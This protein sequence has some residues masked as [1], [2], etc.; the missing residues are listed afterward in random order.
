MIDFIQGPLVWISFIIFGGGLVVQTF[1]L[2]KLTRIKETRRVVP[3]KGFI[4]QIDL[5]IK[6]R[7]FRYLVFQRVSPLAN[8]ICLVLASFIFH[9]CLIVTPIFVLGHNIMLDTAFGISFIS[10]PEQVTDIMTKFVLAGALMFLMR[11]LLLRR[12]RIISTVNDYLLLLI[13]VAPFVTGFMVY[14]HILNYNT[15]ILLH[16]LFGEL[17]LIMI[18]FSKF[19]HMVFFFISRF[20][21]VS[22]HSL[23]NS[24][25]SWHF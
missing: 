11:R 2:L 20:M 4:P 24:K 16:I 10:F 6:E 8:N 25:R 9:V 5:S 19:F 17:M 13:A 22:E 18:P 14:H 3:D 15:I 12:V 21:I 7:L 1:R 23:G